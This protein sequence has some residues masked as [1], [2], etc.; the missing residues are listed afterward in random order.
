MLRLAAL[1]A[2]AEPETLQSKLK[3]STAETARLAQANVRHAAFSPA[4]PEREAQGFIYRHGAEAFVDGAL[5]AWAGSGDAP[6]DAARAQRVTPA[7]A[8]AGAGAAGARR[9][10]AGTRRAP[11][12]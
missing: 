1:A 4:S 2:G 5:M 7:G 3:L 6:A 12:A 8:L 10:R 9:R 11:R